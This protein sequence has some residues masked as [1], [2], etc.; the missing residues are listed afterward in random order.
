MVHEQSYNHLLIITGIV[1][2]HLTTTVS[3]PCDHE[4]KLPSDRNEQKLSV[5]NNNSPNKS[6]VTNKNMTKI[7]MNPPIA[8]YTLVDPE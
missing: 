5:N 2:K 8:L 7:K 6:V 3:S 1:P 4:D